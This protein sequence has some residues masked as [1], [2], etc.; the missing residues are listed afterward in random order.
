MRKEANKTFKTYREHKHY[1]GF[2]KKKM[3]R[4]SKLQANRKQPFSP[5]KWNQKSGRVHVSLRF[6]REVIWRKFRL[7]L[8]P[9]RFRNIPVSSIT[10]KFYEE[11]FSAFSFYNKN[12]CIAK[13]IGRH[14]NWKIAYFYTATAKN[15]R[16]KIRDWFLRLTQYKSLTLSHLCWD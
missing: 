3:F 13:V 12:C 16:L 7:E 8:N 4:N 6:I 1:T 5:W 2:A 11:L 10:G 14:I 9:I 15:V